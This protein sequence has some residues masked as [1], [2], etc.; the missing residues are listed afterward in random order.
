MAT[1]LDS[2]PPASARPTGTVTFNSQR[3]AKQMR[4][5]DLGRD[6]LGICAATILLAAC[7]GSQTPTASPGLA[8]SGLAAPSVRSLHGYYL[9]K[10]NTEVGSSPASSFCFRFMPS[11]R[12]NSTGSIYFYGTYLMSGRELFASAVWFASPAGY[13]SLQGSVNATQGS[14]E[15]IISGESA[16]TTGGGT[17]TMTREQNSDCS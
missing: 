2:G 8:G 11:G 13:M 1:Q 17:F 14:G 16:N 12:W 10:F 7:G 3:G 4:N 15:F 5:F 6:A 9:A